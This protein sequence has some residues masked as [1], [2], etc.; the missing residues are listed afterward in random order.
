MTNT[1]TLLLQDS[2]RHQH[3]CPEP[4]VLQLNCHHSDH[5]ILFI[6]CIMIITILIMNITT[7]SSILSWFWSS[8]LSKFSQY[9]LTWWTLQ[10]DRPSS[11]SCLP[12]PSHR[13]SSY[14]RCPNISELALFGW[15]N[16][17]L[18][19]FIFAKMEIWFFRHASFSSTYPCH[20]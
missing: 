2:L 18:Q 15:H 1:L 17:F 7:T 8:L 3:S 10:R 19:H 13:S 16:S 9:P 11:W 12:P 14:P 6:I 4:W 20:M 5:S